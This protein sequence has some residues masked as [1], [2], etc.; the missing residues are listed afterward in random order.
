[1]PKRIWKIDPGFYCPIAMYCYSPAEQKRIL[2]KSQRKKQKLSQYDLHEF[3]ISSMKNESPLAIRMEKMLNEKYRDEIE[4]WSEYSPHQWKK[5]F[6][7]NFGYKSFGSLLWITAIMPNLPNS[8]SLYLYGKIHLFQIHQYNNHQAIL[9][10]SRQIEDKYEGLN[11]KYSMVRKEL[12]GVK[13]EVQNDVKT[14]SLENEDYKSRINSQENEIAQLTSELDELLSRPVQAENDKLSKQV[15]KLE[16]RLDHQDSTIEALTLEKTELETDLNEQKKLFEDIRTEM[17]RM[18]TT[19]KSNFTQDCECEYAH[20][21]NRR[22]LLVGGMS[23]LLSHY[24]QVVANFGG[25]FEYHNGNSNN[26]NSALSH[27]IGRS[28]III[29][30]VDV[31]SHGACLTVKKQCKKL[32]KPFYM[33]PNSSISSVYRTLLDIAQESRN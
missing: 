14:K 17:E 6:D 19:F 31:N 3:L 27:H 21:C 33:L 22:V 4:E 16:R 11:H 30:P 9:Q 8:I 25:V 32:N 7:A 26:S 1:M 29:C 13:Y 12:E 28:D 18:L 24:R 2:K 15:K 5:L 20:L 23:K 10:R